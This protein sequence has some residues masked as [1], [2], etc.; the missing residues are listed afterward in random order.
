MVNIFY[1]PSSPSNK[2]YTLIFQYGCDYL[3]LMETFLL[4][5][6][7]SE[8]IISSLGCQGMQFVSRL[9]MKR[10]FSDDVL[11]RF[12]EQRFNNSRASDCQEPSRFDIES[13][14][15]SDSLDIKLE[16][17]SFCEG[18]MPTN[19]VSFPI[20]PPS[21]SFTAKTKPGA[22]SAQRKFPRHYL[23]G[24]TQW[25]DRTDDIVDRTPIAG[26]A[27][28]FQGVSKLKFCFTWNKGRRERGNSSSAARQVRLEATRTRNR[29]RFSNYVRN[30]FQRIRAKLSK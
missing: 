26:T 30:F 21:P 27:D 25:I 10:S 3:K 9:I 16:T 6:S 13:D 11:N 14:T 17:N 19:Y 1:T 18:W 12:D 2:L 29:S 5:N 15:D 28:V 7:K 22:S 20:T 23:V 24:Q 4:R 8:V